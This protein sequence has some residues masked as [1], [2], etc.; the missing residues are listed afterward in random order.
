M[1]IKNYTSPGS[2]TPALDLQIIENVTDVFVRAGCYS[3]ANGAEG[4]GESGSPTT[5]Y[6]DERVDPNKFTRHV[7]FSR[8]GVRCRLIVTNHAYICNDR[9]QTI[10]KV[11]A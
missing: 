4:M 7:D 6:G 1:I 9:G 10:E 3:A 11:S 5:V 8:E 2:L